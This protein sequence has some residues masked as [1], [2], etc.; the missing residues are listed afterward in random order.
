MITIQS[1][2]SGNPR[3]CTVHNLY[4]HR[5][6]KDFAVD[7]VDALPHIALAHLSSPVAVADSPWHTDNIPPQEYVS[8]V[9]YLS[10]LSC[11]MGALQAQSR[12][13]SK[14]CLSLHSD[15]EI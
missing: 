10:T 8:L 1:I 14:K 2:I 5:K 9:L 7:A 3:S 11:T 15:G 13:I 4:S 6:S 12:Y